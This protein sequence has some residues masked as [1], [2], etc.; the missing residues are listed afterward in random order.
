MELRSC[1]GGLVQ[2]FEQKEEEY[3]EGCTNKF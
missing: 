2:K 1:I 3:D